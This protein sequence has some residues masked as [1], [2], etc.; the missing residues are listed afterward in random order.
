MSIYIAHRRK[1]A[2]ND[3]T[4]LWPTWR[5]NSTGLFLVNFVRCPCDV[6]GTI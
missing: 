6:F 1:N 5:L 4:K 2:S 3:P